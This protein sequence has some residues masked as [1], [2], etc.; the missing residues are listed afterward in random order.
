MS[1]KAGIKYQ[2]MN[3]NSVSKACDAYRD[4]NRDSAWKACNDYQKKNDNSVWKNYNGKICNFSIVGPVKNLTVMSLFTP[5]QWSA[6]TR[7]TGLDYNIIYALR[8]LPGRCP[9]L[10]STSAHSFK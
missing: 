6:F 2:D 8:F 3:G 9:V 5:G 4:T 7:E 10:H 1:Q